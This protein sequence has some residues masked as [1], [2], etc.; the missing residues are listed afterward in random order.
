M[1]WIFESVIAVCGGSVGK[2]MHTG[3]L[4]DAP[5]FLQTILQTVQSHEPAVRSVVEKGEA[6]L[7]MVRDPT[8]SDNMAKLG[9]DYQELCSTARVKEPSNENNWRKKRT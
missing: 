4:T 8:V 5:V 7:E 6:L 3:V 9:S 2:P 1:C